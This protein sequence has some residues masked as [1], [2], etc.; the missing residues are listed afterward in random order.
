MAQRTVLLTGFPGFLAGRLVPRCSPT[1]PRPR[2]SRSSSRGWSQRAREAAARLDGVERARRPGDITD[3]RAS[4]S[5]P[6]RYDA[7]A[8]RDRRGAPPR[9]RLRPRGRR[10]ARRARQRPG[11]AARRR[12]LPRAATRLERHNYVSTAYVAGLRSGPRARGRARRRPGAS[13]TTTSRRSSPPRS[14]CATSMDE[15]P[16]TIY[17][18]AIVV[19]DSRTGETQKFDGPYYLLRTIVGDQGAAAAGRQRRRAVQRRAGRLRRRRDRRRRARRRRRRG[20][21]AAPRRPRAARVVRA[22]PAAGRRVRRARAALPRAAGACVDRSLRY[23]AVRRLYGGTPRESMRY[24]NHPVRFDTTNAVGRCSAR[25]G[26][27]CPRFPEYVGPMVRFF[28]EHE[29]DDALPP[30]ARALASAGSGAARAQA[31]EEHLEQLVPAAARR[32]GRRPGGD[33]AAERAHER[34][35]VVDA[36]VRGAARRPAWARAMSFVALGESARARSAAAAE[37]LRRAPPTSSAARARSC[38]HR[39]GALAHE[40][41]ERL[42]RVLDLEVDAA[43]ARRSAR[44]SADRARPISASLV[45]KWR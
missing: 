11:H 26:L 31:V 39:L 44:T 40:A 17:R 33:G 18:P 38:C 24:L 12:L 45:G 37:R 13:R 35:H 42:P 20:P 23:A 25:Q 3:G 29:H 34:R 4:A 8:A 9:R 21:H 28:R 32:A 7:L 30:G 2:S 6:R 19:G 1:T 22:L 27:R 14:S 5:T 36:E 16:T 43:R 10:R 15:V 41:R